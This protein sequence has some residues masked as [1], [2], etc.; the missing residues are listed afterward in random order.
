VTMVG[1]RWAMPTV[2]SS[3]PEKNKK[4]KKNQQK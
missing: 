4:N 2:R 1:F 3:S